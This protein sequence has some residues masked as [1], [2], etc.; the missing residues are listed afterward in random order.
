MFPAR[1]DSGRSH[2]YWLQD[3]SPLC[4]AGCQGTA[5]NAYH[6]CA[7]LAWQLRMSNGAWHPGKIS[8]FKDLGIRLEPPDNPGSSPHFK[9]FTSITCTK[10]FLPWEVTYPQVLEIRV[11]ASL[12]TTTQ[13]VTLPHER[14]WEGDDFIQHV[15]SSRKTLDIW[16]VV[17]A[18]PLTSS[19]ILLSTFNM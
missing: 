9:I 17:P 5:H 18:G 8:I 12:E 15:M 19:L 4:F 16:T 3:W 1:S 11:W 7:I 14:N 13:P 10:S 2:F 6:L